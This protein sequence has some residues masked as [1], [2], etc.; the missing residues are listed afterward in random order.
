VRLAVDPDHLDGVLGELGSDASVEPGTTIIAISV[1]NRA[2]FR[3]VVLG[4]LEH[5]E[6]LEPAD[7]RADV[8]AWLE[9]VAAT[10]A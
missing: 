8:V 2:A 4:F 3:G 5:V 9:E 6:V 7:V 1:T 10:P